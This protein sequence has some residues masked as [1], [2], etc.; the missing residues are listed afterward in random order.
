M[1][2]ATIAVA[3]CR[4]DDGDDRQACPSDIEVRVLGP[5]Q[6]VGA[7]RPFRRPRALD[8]V[9]Y[10]AMQ[11]RPVPTDRWAGALWP[12][13][14]P[15][16]PTL[17]S[18][19]SDARRALGRSESGTDHLPGRRGG[20]RLANSV[21]T[22][23]DRFQQLADAG[24]PAS[25]RCAL[26]L[27]R[28]RPFDGLSCSDWTVLEGFVAEMEERIGQLAMAAARHALAGGDGGGATWAARRGLRAAPYDERLYR[29]LLRAADREGNRTGLA[30]LM[31]E[32]LA[33]VGACCPGRAQLTTA[34]LAEL[35][36]P[37]TAALY[38]RLSAAPS[39]PPDRPV[40][41]T[42]SAVGASWRQVARL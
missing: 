20:L 13:R 7:A 36:H 2:Q 15:M 10:L 23:W 26:E 8:L 9:V 17:H 6:I 40:E 22:D 27:V 1:R 34:A 35:V 12:D 16:A 32:L 41:V 21:G 19:V 3:G 42:P 38:R 37:E 25:L 39:D 29:L 14:L 33:V 30:A 24:D 5:V 11:G 28:G 31:G 18:T 4:A